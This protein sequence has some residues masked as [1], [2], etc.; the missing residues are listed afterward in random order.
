MNGAACSSCRR[1]NLECILNIPQQQGHYLKFNAQPDVQDPKSPGLS[2]SPVAMKI[3]LSPVRNELAHQRPTTN[4][5][6]GCYDHNGNT[7]GPISYNSPIG[8]NS[9]PS[10]P[11]G[12]NTL[13]DIFGKFNIEVNGRAEFLDDHDQQDRKTSH[14]KDVF[15]FLGLNGPPVLG[16]PVP[17]DPTYVPA[18]DLAMILFDIY[19]GDIHPYI[20]IIDKTQFLQD[21]V[22]RRDAMNPYLLFSIFGIAARFS[23]DPRVLFDPN[24]WDSRGNL[25]WNW[26][27]QHQ[28]DFLDAPRLTTLQAYIINL[29]AQET[30]PHTKG[31]MYRGWL[32]LSVIIRM[33]KDLSLHR[34]GED[35]KLQNSELTSGR[36]IW[37]VAL[38]MDQMMGSA[39]GREFQLN[40]ADVDVTLPEATSD[41]DS[42]EVEIHSD[43]VYFVGLIKILRRMTEVHQSVGVKFPFAVEPDY[44]ALRKVLL[45]WHAMLPG[46]LQCD[47]V[48]DTV[49]PSHFVAHLH[50]VRQIMRWNILRH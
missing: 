11:P 34:L 15:K 26:E 16:F 30:R 6:P 20:P 12:I 9:C 8:Q 42:G 43:F 17:L 28:L 41:I 2:N 44:P 32:T 23:T 46:R 25:W 18:D 33:G 22:H 35:N 3:P 38:F 10:S 50:I 29:K 40:T 13:T 21:W 31:Y 1:L 39:Q 5:S 49:L 27:R 36:R 37:Q 4:Q 19:F 45:Q 14:N 7:D 48:E 47:A 24:D